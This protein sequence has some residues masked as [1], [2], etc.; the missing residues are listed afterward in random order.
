M[1]PETTWWSAIQVPLQP[2]II[3]HGVIQA[4]TITKIYGTRRSTA[5]SALARGSVN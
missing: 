2:V 3:I 1:A 5:A 4:E